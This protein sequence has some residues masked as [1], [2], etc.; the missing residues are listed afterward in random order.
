MER[1]N[2]RNQSQA[3]VSWSWQARTYRQPGGD[4]FSTFSVPLLI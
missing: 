2:T 4:T 1:A 3:V